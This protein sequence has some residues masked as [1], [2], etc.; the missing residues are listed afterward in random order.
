MRQKPFAEGAYAPFN[1][2]A[3]WEPFLSEE[4]DV[5][6]WREPAPKESAIRKFRHI[7]E[8]HNPGKQLFVLIGKYAAENGMKAL[9]HEDR[10]ASQGIDFL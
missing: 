1:K 4:E 8:A 2:P 9:W 3:I 10:M 7:L 5:F 6:P